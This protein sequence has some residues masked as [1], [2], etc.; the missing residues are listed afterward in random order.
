MTTV[1]TPPLGGIRVL[2]VPSGYGT[3]YAYVQNNPSLGLIFKT[4]VVTM[5]PRDND[6]VIVMQ[7]ATT[8]TSGL[9]ET[10]RAP[11]TA[12]S[13]TLTTPAAAR[14]TL[15]SWIRERCAI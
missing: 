15:S 12:L 8:M 3:G 10:S 9:S 1:N 5:V 4:V 11:R 2:R 7:A 13:L 6:N 14:T